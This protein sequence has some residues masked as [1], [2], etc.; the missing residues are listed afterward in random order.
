MSR[1]EATFRR[2]SISL[3]AQILL[4]QMMIRWWDRLNG[5]RTIRSRSHV[6]S[7]TKT[8]MMLKDFEGVVSPAVGALCVD[9]TIGSKTLPTTFFVINGK[10]SY[11]SLLGRD[12]IHANCCIPSTMHQC[13]IQWIGDVVEVV[14]ANCCIP[15][16][17]HQCL[18]QWIGDVVEVVAADSSFSIASAEACEENYE[19]V[20][21]FSGQAWEAEFLK[22]ADYEISSSSASE[23]TDES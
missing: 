19:R 1:R 5:F 6:L 21:C 13:L 16:T 8:D 11:S 23:S 20:K 18:I 17:M 12:W 14:A 15:S 22:V 10:G 7:V 9:L 3:T 4:I 2:K